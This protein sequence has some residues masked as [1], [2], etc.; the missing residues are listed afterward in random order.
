MPARSTFPFAGIALA[1][2]AGAGMLVAGAG[3]WLV[4]AV[5][6]LWFGLTRAGDCG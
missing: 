3:L 1:L 4:L 5:M 2:I 6:A